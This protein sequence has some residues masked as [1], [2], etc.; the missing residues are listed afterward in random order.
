[1]K[2]LS[3]LLALLMIFTCCALASCSEEETSSAPEASS[4]APATSSEAPAASS[5]PEAESSEEAPAESSEEEVSTEPEYVK[6]PDAIST[7]GNN[8]AAGK[9]YTISEQFRMGGAD[10]G[11]GWDENA[12][13]SY[14]DDGFE[15]TDGQIPLN[16]YR[17]A[18]WMAFNQSTPAQT[19]RGYGYVQF[20]LGQS[21]EISEVTIHSLKETSPGITCPHTIEILVSEDNETWYSAA[22]LSLMNELEGYEDNTVHALVAEMDVTGRYVEIR[23]TSHTWG[24]MGE[25][26]IK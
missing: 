8:V 4:T 13:P 23:V 22:T 1:M 10:V 19:E 5:E 21:Y 2:K 12:A 24:F 26:E 17:E 3:L 20:D 16:D 7:E 11:W 25:I 15:L 6:N 9:E 18:G 14:P